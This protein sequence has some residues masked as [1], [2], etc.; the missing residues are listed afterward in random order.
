MRPPR[1]NTPHLIDDGGLTARQLSTLTA[2]SQI[3]DHVS[4]DEPLSFAQIVGRIQEDPDA[5]P[6]STD[7]RA[8]DALLAAQ[9]ISRRGGGW[10]TRYVSPGR[11]VR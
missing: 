5:V 10:M 2:A 8:L 11:R 7:R 9:L 6:S 1:D 3:L 4:T